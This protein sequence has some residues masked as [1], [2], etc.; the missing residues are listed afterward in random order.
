M[1]KRAETEQQPNRMIKQ[2]QERMSDIYIHAESVCVCVEEPEGSITSQAASMH[3]TKKWIHVQF[4]YSIGCSQCLNRQLKSQFALQMISKPIFNYAYLHA[5][6]ISFAFSNTLPVPTFNCHFLDDSFSP[7]LAISHS[8]ARSL[9]LSH[10]VHTLTIHH[11]L[12]NFSHV[13][14]CVFR[15]MLCAIA[16]DDVVATAT[17]NAVTIKYM[18]VSSIEHPN[19][20]DNVLLLHVL[21]RI[22]LMVTIWFFFKQFSLRMCVWVWVSVSNQSSVDA[23]RYWWSEL[24]FYYMFSFLFSLSLSLSLWHS[25]IQPNYWVSLTHTP[26]K[27]HSEGILSRWHSSFLHRY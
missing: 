14:R 17:L 3:E 6:C 12:L 4:R 15:L 9:I 13:C 2:M 20:I 25:S 19:E 21:I 5:I 16:A 1:K 24:F 7:S 11:I 18:L 26:C 10:F 22:I 8:F 27:K 23:V